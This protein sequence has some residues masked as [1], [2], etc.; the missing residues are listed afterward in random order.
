MVDDPEKIRKFINS[1]SSKVISATMESIREDIV[2]LPLDILIEFRDTFMKSC[3][4]NPQQFGSNEA[5][6]IGALKAIQDLFD[7]EIARKKALH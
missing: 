7:A 6:T 1:G 2:A 5:M 3:L 4:E